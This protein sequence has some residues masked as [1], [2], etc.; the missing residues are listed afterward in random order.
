MAKYRVSI[1]SAIP[2][3]LLQVVDELA[4]AAGVTRSTMIRLLLEDSIPA[5]VLARDAARAAVQGEV[6]S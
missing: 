3:E 4:A 1:S 5:A 6:Q 2:V